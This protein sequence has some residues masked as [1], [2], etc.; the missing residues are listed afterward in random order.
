MGLAASG[1]YG[2]AKLI[3]FDAAVLK[4]WHLSQ[5]FA[6]DEFT[7]HLEAQLLVPPTG[8]AG[9]LDFSIPTLGISERL[10][11]EFDGVDTNAFVKQDVKANAKDVELWWPVGLG[12]QTL[13]DLTVKYISWQR[14]MGALDIAD[15]AGLGAA[16]RLPAKTHGR[17]SLLNSK[18]LPA[19]LAKTLDATVTGTPADDVK[20]FTSS[21]TKKV[22]FRVVE[23]VRKPLAEAAEMLLGNGGWNSANKIQT[24]TRQCFWGGTCGQW[25]WVN[26]SRWEF[27][28]DPVRDV[29]DE[30]YY[31]GKRL[32]GSLRVIS[33]QPAISL[34]ELFC[35]MLWFC[36]IHQGFICLC[37]LIAGK[38]C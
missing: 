15:P 6:G 1:I 11:V 34:G 12:N 32:W 30:K 25:G 9:F 3:A 4:G 26:G 10:K 8:D 17:R 31:T 23:L 18:D 20:D 13:Y 27:I 37:C 29:S 33:F 36:S 24:G 7:L 19:T 38:E 35:L 5:T 21:I 14:L 2:G 22:G 16:M 28:S